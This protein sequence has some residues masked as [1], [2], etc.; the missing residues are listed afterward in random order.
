MLQCRCCRH[1]RNC[2]RCRD[3]V[4]DGPMPPAPEPMPAELI[5]DQPDMNTNGIW[6]LVWLFVIT[7]V[8]ALICMG[9]EIFFPS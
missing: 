1:R 8:G 2:C 5:D 9:K 7:A 4:D 6:F 3:F